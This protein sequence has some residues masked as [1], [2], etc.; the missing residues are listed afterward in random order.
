MA[1]SARRKA[2]TLIVIIH[3]ILQFVSLVR[4]LPVASQAFAIFCRGYSFGEHFAEAV[5]SPRAPAFPPTTHARKA[6]EF[7]RAN[8][9]APQQKQM[10]SHA[11][12]GSSL[13]A[14]GPVTHV[15]HIAG[16][17]VLGC[18]SGVGPESHWRR[19]TRGRASGTVRQ[20]GRPRRATWRRAEQLEELVTCFPAYSSACSFGRSR[21]SSNGQAGPSRRQFELHKGRALAL[22][23]HGIRRILAH[24]GQP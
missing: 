9:Q 2:S 23:A 1:G 20:K 18:A 8:A 6:L 11:V 14:S 24:W 21:E 3:G 16:T 10:T 5:F 13:A 22:S 15:P 7:Q 4:R 17:S 19:R 12:V